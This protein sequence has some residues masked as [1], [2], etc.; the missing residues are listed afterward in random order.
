MVCAVGLSAPGCA[1]P[2]RAT[3]EH[4]AGS[5]HHQGNGQTEVL[6][7]VILHAVVDKAD[8]HKDCDVTHG[9]HWR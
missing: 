5:F 4:T 3:P 6:S 7:A 9:N 2:R 8:N 1:A